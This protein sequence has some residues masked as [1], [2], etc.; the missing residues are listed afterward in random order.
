MKHGS[1]P[2]RGRSRGNGKRHP[3]SRN[4]NFESSGPDVKI[5]GTA[6]QVQ[7]K[8]L[9]LARDASS[10]GDR[11]AAEGYYQHAEHYFRLASAAAGIGGDG[12]HNRNPRTTT[13]VPPPPASGSAFEGESLPAPGDSIPP[14]TVQPRPVD[15]PAIAET[16][17]AAPAAAP[18]MTSDA[19]PDATGPGPA[20]AP[21]AATGP[22]PA[23]AAD[24]TGGTEPKT[25][26]TR[27]R[28]R[29]KSIPAV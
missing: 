25:P 18:Q 27:N 6:Q 24:A 12:D 5:R 21:P 9:N 11:I 10:A 16:P 8:Y 1:N 3:A 2:R 15:G 26:G 29:K 19:A 23:D 22:G 13:Q 17:E 14:A 7:E 20:D 4:Q 28:S